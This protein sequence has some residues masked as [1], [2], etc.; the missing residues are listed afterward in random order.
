MIGAAREIV[1]NQKIER[2]LETSWPRRSWHGD[3]EKR[4]V[5]GAG[6]GY[7]IEAHSPSL[8]TRSWPTTPIAL[9]PRNFVTSNKEATLEAEVSKP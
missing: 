8:P 3:N 2:E 1:T 9:L 4:N 7:G 5:R 6:W